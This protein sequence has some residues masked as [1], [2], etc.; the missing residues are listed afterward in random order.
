MDFKKTLILS[1]LF[2]HCF[3]AVALLS[4]DL[5]KGIGKT[6][7]K[8]VFFVKLLE[9]GKREGKVLSQNVRDLSH[10]APSLIAKESPH[11]PAPHPVRE[12]P[13]YHLSPFAGELPL[14]LPS[15]RLG[16]GKGEGLNVHEE[17][18][19]HTALANYESRENAGN[20][21][22]AVGKSRETSSIEI[23]EIIRNSIERVKTYP[24]LARKRGI[25][26]TVHISFGIS[27]QGKPQNIKI[28]KSSGSNILDTA[29]LDIVKKASPLPYIDSPVE[30]PVV[31][32]LTE[33]PRTEI[34][35]P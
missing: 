12:S 26:G 25:E 31:F 30:I 34:E 20:E 29:T 14:Q 11:Q 3:F 18:S 8:K 32:K 19:G 9:E 1:V 4:A 22:A 2:H 24:L 15:P 17:P 21:G 28:L 7:E 5:S 33:Y 23:I 13:Y 10:Q 35:I 16:E 6:H 27:R